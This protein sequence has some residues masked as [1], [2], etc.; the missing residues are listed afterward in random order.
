MPALVGRRAVLAGSGA[1]L[2]AWPRG[3]RAQPAAGVRRIGYLGISSPSLEPTYVEAF[4]QQLRALGYV[5]ERDIAIDFRW[6]EGHDERLPALAAELVRRR[7]VAI[8]TTGRE[9]PRP[10]ASRS[11]APGSR[12]AR[13]MRSPRPV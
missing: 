11:P 8:I 7:P 3:A 13:R 10:D 2:L 5:E 1:A 6:A 9:G 4:R 12:S